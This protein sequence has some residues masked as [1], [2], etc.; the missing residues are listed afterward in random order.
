[1]YP[2]PIKK[3]R[4]SNKNKF[5]D[6]QK[7]YLNAYSL[8]YIEKEEAKNEIKKLEAIIEEQK[9]TIQEL[10]LK[11]RENVKNADAMTQTGAH[12]QSVFL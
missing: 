9:Q 3:L 10:M 11:T 1:M 5:T 8:L 6:F 4:R 7:S 2:Y 12:S